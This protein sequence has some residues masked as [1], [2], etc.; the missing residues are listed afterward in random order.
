MKAL[1]GTE[2]TPT[3]KLYEAVVPIQP[4]RVHGISV[5]GYFVRIIMRA[6]DEGED[7]E[8]PSQP[9]RE[10]RALRPPI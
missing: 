4:L 7:R 2:V 1:K 3:E 8:W 6:E 10:G 5:G 9:R